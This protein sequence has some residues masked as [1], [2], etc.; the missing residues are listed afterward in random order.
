[1]L[2]HGDVFQVVRRRETYEDQVAGESAWSG[3]L[4]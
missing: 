4:P 1:V 2:V 3:R